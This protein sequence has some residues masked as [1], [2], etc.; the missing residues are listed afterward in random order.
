VVAVGCGSLEHLCGLLAPSV[1]IYRTRHRS[2]KP[3][4]QLEKPVLP[5]HRSSIVALVNVASR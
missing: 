5:Y 4:R 1:L 2:G 3:H